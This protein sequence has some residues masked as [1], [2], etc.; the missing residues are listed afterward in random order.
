M[1]QCES[2]LLSASRAVIFALRQMLRLPTQGFGGLLLVDPGR[3]PAAADGAEESSSTEALVDARMYGPSQ[4]M[5]R[6]S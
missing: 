1:L 4:W 5:V 3:A 6:S 2:P